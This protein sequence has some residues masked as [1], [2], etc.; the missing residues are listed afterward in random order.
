MK[1]GCP[2]TVSPLKK[3]RETVLTP[4]M[5]PAAPQRDVGEKW[6][7]KNGASPPAAITALSI[8]NPV[9]HLVIMFAEPEIVS[10]L[11]AYIPIDETFYNY[12][13]K[14]V[15]VH[16]LESENTSN[17]KVRIVARSPEVLDE[18][19]KKYLSQ[20]SRIH[21]FSRLH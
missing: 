5:E 13:L 11:F 1:E 8:P 3:T 6:C 16:N 18:F 9:V 17:D 12:I 10:N 2:S 19:K 7:A 15:D 4:T 14:T 20:V 21:T